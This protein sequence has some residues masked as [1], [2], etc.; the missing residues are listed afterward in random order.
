MFTCNYSLI[1]RIINR[2]ICFL[3]SLILR[4]VTC[5]RKGYL[6]FVR[7]LELVSMRNLDFQLVGFLKVHFI[8]LESNGICGD[9]LFII[10]SFRFIPCP[11]KVNNGNTLSLKRKSCSFCWWSKTLTK[12]NYWMDKLWHILALMNQVIVLSAGV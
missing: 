2:G 7:S 8:Q 11:E 5:P 6:K 12:S 9:F 4:I 10:S 1:L 3:G